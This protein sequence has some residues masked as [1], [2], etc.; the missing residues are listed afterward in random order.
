M[1]KTVLVGLSG[2][3]DSAACC[4][5]LM[6]EGYDVT[7][8]FL[9]FFDQSAPDRAEIVAKR[10]GV[11]LHIYDCRADFERNVIDYFVREYTE[12]RTPNPCARCNRTM[13]FAS[14]ISFADRLGID[15]VATGHYAGVSFDRQSGRYYVSR[16]KDASKDQSYFLWQLTQK[17][18]SRVLTPLAGTVKKEVKQFCSDIVPVDT[19]E[20]NEICFVPDND[21]VSFIQKRIGDNDNP[22]LREGNFVDINGRVL[23]RHKG[24]F[25][26]TVGQRRGLD[27]SL[28]RRAYVLSVDAASGNI[29]LGY[30]EDCIADAVTVGNLN[31]SGIAE[32]EGELEGCVK[33]RYRQPPAHAR[34]TVS[35]GTASV[36]LLSPSRLSA[37]GQSAV[38]YSDDRLIFG[39]VIK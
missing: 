21:Y 8:C 14:L 6:D 27:I 13:K 25:R 18:L 2:G 1:K 16:G 36:R 4:R 26:Y 23:G 17:Q 10:L 34:V 15:K 38:F 20:S 33:L 7:A 32:F 37:R 22:I 9:R 19:R 35:D 5:I 12:G 31:F 24:I 30:D 28:G 29:V 11:P 39:G 3:V